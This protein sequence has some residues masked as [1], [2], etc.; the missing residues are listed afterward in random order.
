MC[1]EG[2]CYGGWLGGE[3][4]HISLIPLVGWNPLLDRSF[5]LDRYLSIDRYG[6]YRDVLMNEQWVQWVPRFRSFS[7]L[8]LFHS[9]HSKQGNLFV[10][11]SSYPLTGPLRKKAWVK[12]VIYIYIYACLPTWL[13]G[14]KMNLMGESVW[15]TFLYVELAGSIL[16]TLY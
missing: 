14:Y 11:S 9:S 4:G 1:S 8:I 13:T 6:F 7:P 2:W 16:L 12:W 5:P 3:A 10:E 15:E